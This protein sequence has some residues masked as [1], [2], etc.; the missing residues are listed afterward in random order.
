VID[1]AELRYQVERLS[2]GTGTASGLVAFPVRGR[3]G[4]FPTSDDG[5]ILAYAQSRSLVAHL[6]ETY[7]EVA[8]SVLASTWARLP[9]VVSRMVIAGQSTGTPCKF[10]ELGR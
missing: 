10:P 3:A 6:I 7:G 2:C 1:R 8:C 5:A 4:S 9:R